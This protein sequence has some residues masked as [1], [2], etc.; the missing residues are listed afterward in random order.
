MIDQIFNNL[1]AES[2]PVLMVLFV[3]AFALT[4]VFYALI[5][6]RKKKLKTYR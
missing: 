3:L 5:G 6:R 2:L 1:S 4:G